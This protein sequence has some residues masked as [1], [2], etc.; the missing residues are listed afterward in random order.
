MKDV[1]HS[2]FAKCFP[3]V[4]I[5]PEQL[6]QRSAILFSEP[7]LVITYILTLDEEI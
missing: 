7:E 4:C 2:N 3:T 5:S 1:E 6:A